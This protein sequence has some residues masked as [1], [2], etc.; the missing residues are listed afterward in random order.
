MTRYA[1]FTKVSDNISIEDVDIFKGKFGDTNVN[2]EV[3]T[4]EYFAQIS[5]EFEIKAHVLCNFDIEKEK[6]ENLFHKKMTFLVMDNDR[7]KYYTGIITGINQNHSNASDNRPLLVFSVS[8]HTKILN[9]QNGFRSFNE[10]TSHDIIEFF[11]KKIKTTYPNFEFKMLSLNK[12][13]IIRRRNTVQYG[14]SDYNFLLRICEEDKHNFYFDHNEKG[15]IIIFTDDL[16]YAFRQE[17]KG[18]NNLELK[19]EVY[20]QQNAAPIDNKAYGYKKLYNKNVQKIRT[21][22][23]DFRK[24]PATM[25]TAE[26][27]Q[28][29]AAWHNHKNLLSKSQEPIK[30]K[31]S[32]EG[33]YQNKKLQQIVNSGSNLVSFSTYNSN[34][35]IGSEVN[36]DLSHITSSVEK[37]VIIVY[38][39]KEVYN[40]NSYPHCHVTAFLSNSDFHPSINS[41]EKNKI[42]STTS[43]IVAGEKGC[44]P[45]LLDMMLIKIH[46]TWQYPEYTQLSDDSPALSNYVFARLSQTSAGADRGSVIIPRGG[47]E[48]LVAFEH[49]DPELPVIIAS[50]YNNRNYAPNFTPDNRPDVTHFRTSTSENNSEKKYNEVIIDEKKGEEKISVNAKKDFHVKVEENL[51]FKSKECSVS[52]AENNVVTL[53]NGEFTLIVKNSK[54]TIQAKSNVTIEGEDVSVTAKGKMLLNGQQGVTVKGPKKTVTIN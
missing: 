31:D 28:S 53:E 48:V 38:G 2:Y 11:M 36:L 23:Y 29:E 37:E 20:S 54:I 7:K 46:F 10:K 30:H 18:K 40:S 9:F 47:D 52:V 21:F 25:E 24:F 44:A 35:S 3:V 50:L 33:K 12:N 6:I 45:E 4:L 16:E 19:L 5:Q 41:I 14:E 43:A 15:L 26:L 22:D 32:E 8:P 34:I 17:R 51:T 27:K 42:H 1:K 13:T 49:G 39:L